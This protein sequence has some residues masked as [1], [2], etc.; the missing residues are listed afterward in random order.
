[1]PSQRENPYLVVEGPIGTGKTTL[2]KLLGKEFGARL[3]LERVEENPFLRRFYEDPTQYAFSTQLYFLLTRY[4][5]Q[6]DLVQRE[7]FHGGLVSD[8]L[9]SKDRI[10]AKLNLNAD[11]FALYQELYSLLDGRLPRPD[12]VIY[13]QAT[14]DVLLTRVRKRALNYERRVTPAYLER[15]AEAYKEFFFHYEEAPL[16]VVDCSGIDF[17]AH[18]EDLADLVREIRQAGAGVQHYIPRAAR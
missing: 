6:Q 11:E 16:L 14:V 12:L 7:L 1:M 18:P 15:V 9:F 3:L 13:M 4:R 10:F 5:Q 8:Y 17:V 2:A